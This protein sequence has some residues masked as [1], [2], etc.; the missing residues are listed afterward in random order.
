MAATAIRVQEN[1]QRSS[2]LRGSYGQEW[3][4][5]EGV[6]PQNAHI[7]SEAQAAGLPKIGELDV[8]GQS[9]VYRTNVVLVHNS[10]PGQES[11]IVQVD[12]RPTNWNVSRYLGG[13]IDKSTYIK[14]GLPI[15][16]DAAVGIQGP[17]IVY[18]PYWVYEEKFDVVARSISYRTETR[19]NPGKT[20]DQIQTFRDKNLGKLY[21]FGNR[22][23]NDVTNYV[24]DNIDAKADRGNNIVVTVY[25]RTTG[26]VKGYP[27]NYFGFNHIAIPSLRNLEAYNPR[28]T[29][30]G[31][32]NNGIIVVTAEEMYDVGEPVPWL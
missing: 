18:Q 11:C 13:T 16:Y 22:V 15:I 8:Y 17:G 6:K 32:Y 12:Y 14:W 3:W 1:F 10:A 28:G 21:K 7:S 20:L 9:I 29:V 19:S 30:A 27:P 24:L 5:V 25:F 31:G 2:E 23:Q 4:V 26:P